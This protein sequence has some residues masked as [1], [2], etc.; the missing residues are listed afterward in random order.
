MAVF[1]QGISLFWNGWHN[2]LIRRCQY[3]KQLASWLEGH[4]HRG[5]TSSPNSLI[6]IIFKELPK[7]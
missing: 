5:S 2:N 7:T 4:A 6:K 1:V 3:L